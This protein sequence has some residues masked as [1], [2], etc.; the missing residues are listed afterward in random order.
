[1]SE[2]S[3]A[4]GWLAI[5]LVAIL[6][7]LILGYAWG[8]YATWPRIRAEGY[9]QGVATCEINPAPEEMREP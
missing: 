9:R 7:A 1:M 4:N 3:R 2:Q 8:A 6:V 5:L